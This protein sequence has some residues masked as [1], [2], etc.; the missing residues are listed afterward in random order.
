MIGPKNKPQVE[1]V[2]QDGNAFAIMGAVSSALRKAGAD[3]EYIDQYHD[4]A[5]SGDYDHLIQV[6]MA[7]VDVL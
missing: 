2:G 5:T 4:K 1:L 6:T 7:Y 3:N